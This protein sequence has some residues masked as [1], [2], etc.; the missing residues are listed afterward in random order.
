MRQEFWI[1]TIP[2]GQA[3][4]KFA[5]V[6]NH[7]HTYDPKHSKDYK[8]DMKWQIIEQHPIVMQ[9]PVSL[10]VDFMMPRPKAH[11]N[12]KGV[13]DSAPYYHTSKPDLDN[14]VKA[15]KDCAKGVLWKDDSQVCVTMATKKYAEVP[16]IK[17]YIQ[18]M[19]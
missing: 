19:Q 7:V 15:L 14:M 16:G 6:G 2:A 12:K 18:D 9:G 13:K 8:A 1:S 5:R 4:P 3:R 17:F 11:Y 10:I